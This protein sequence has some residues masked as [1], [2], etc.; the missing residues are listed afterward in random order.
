MTLT[1]GLPPE[2]YQTIAESFN[3]FLHEDRQALARLALCSRYL[4]LEAERVLYEQFSGFLNLNTHLQF[5]LSVALRGRASFVKQYSLE[6][7]HR[8]NPP[9]HDFGAHFSNALQS[10][11]NLKRLALDGVDGRWICNRDYDFQIE[12]FKWS[13]TFVTYTD[14]SYQVMD[15]HKFILKQKSLKKLIHI[16]RALTLNLE[17]LPHITSL[18]SI[19][20]IWL[21]IPQLLRIGRN[22]DS[23]IWRGGIY[24][25][26]QRAV[27]LVATIYTLASSW[28]RLRILRFRCHSSDQLIPLKYLSRYL[29]NLEVLDIPNSFKVC[30]QVLRFFCSRLS[31]LLVWPR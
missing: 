30:L 12:V 8:Q 26:P 6:Y 23:L 18:T 2:L 5:F 13:P 14:D 25:D 19:D 16:D 1:M 29:H 11:R 9:V 31:R 21:Y 7:S 3:T 28:K 20:A 27:H 10:F 4:N 15:I 22:V 17:N 24:C